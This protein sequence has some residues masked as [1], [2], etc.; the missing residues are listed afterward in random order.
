MCASAR[1]SADVASLGASCA[2]VV[3]ATLDTFARWLL[4]YPTTD[5]LPGTVAP[6]ART[7]AMSPAAQWSLK[8]VTAVGAATPSSRAAARSPFSSV[9]AATLRLPG[10]VL[11][12][13]DVGLDLPR[14]ERL[15]LVGTTGR[16]V[17]RDP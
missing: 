1:S 13:F 4:S 11:G 2:M 16:I 8:A 3:S 12:Q 6:R 9:L 15:E 7:V 14:R 5:R 17:V 10:D